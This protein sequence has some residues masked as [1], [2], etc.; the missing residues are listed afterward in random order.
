MPCE[1]MMPKCAH[2]GLSTIPFSTYRLSSPIPPVVTVLP[3]LTSPALGVRIHQGSLLRP[4]RPLLYRNIVA[5]TLADTPSGYI[6]DPSNHPRQM[7]S[8]ERISPQSQSALEAIEMERKL[9][10]SES[11]AFS[12]YTTLRIQE[13]KKVLLTEASTLAQLQSAVQTLEEELPRLAALVGTVV[14]KPITSAKLFHLKLQQHQRRLSDNNDVFHV[15]P[16]PLPEYEIVTGED[17]EDCILRRRKRREDDVEESEEAPLLESLGKEELDPALIQPEKVEVT[18]RDVNHVR[19]LLGVGYRR[20]SKFELAETVLME[21]LNSD[22]GNADAIESLLEMYAGMSAAGRIQTL[23]EFLSREYKREAIR[24]VGE[25]GPQASA[26]PTPQLTIPTSV[27]EGAHSDVVPPDEGIP[28]YEDH[29]SDEVTT[30]SVLTPV[31]LAV[32]LLADMIVEAAATHC[33]EHGEGSTCRF[34]LTALEPFARHLERAFLGLLLEALFRSIDEQHYLARFGNAEAADTEGPVRYNQVSLSPDTVKLVYALVIAFL[35]TL[36]ARRLDELV[37]DPL[38][39]RF[40]VLTKLHA[41]LR[42]AGRKHESYAFA[43]QLFDLYRANSS[44]HRQR[45]AAAAARSQGGDPNHAPGPS[46]GGDPNSSATRRRE[47]EGEVGKGA[48]DDQDANYQAALFQYLHDRA[49]DSAVEGRRLC[50]AAM[51]EFPESAAPWETLAMLLRR[52]NPDGAGRDAIT[53]ARR[54]LRLEPLRLS[55]LLTCATL[56]REAGQAEL[57]AWLL[58]RYREVGDR[59]GQGVGPAGLQAIAD[60]ILRV[61]ESHAMPWDTSEK[62]EAE[63]TE[64][65]EEGGL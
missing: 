31:E 56:Y 64:G 34:F 1:R 42:S 13:N 19:Y 51:D 2:C 59:L 49:Q 41:A 45:M 3:R 53:A 29:L 7:V 16:A 57:S 5:N 33:A 58:D 65:R 48:L 12:G 14:D 8:Y 20:L 35:K 55:L 4:T 60:E 10:E 25:G 11:L 32:T 9:M 21:I 44:L 6:Q 47:G 27:C 40:F 52:E 15:A 17:G 61:T 63:G 36:L 30:S 23:L 37:V 50:L 43:K 54:G 62:G 26:N 28:T 38:R 18:V 39:F 24:G 46:P 22:I